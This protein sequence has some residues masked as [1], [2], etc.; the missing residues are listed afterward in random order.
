LG[1]VIPNPPWRVRDLL[2]GL[3]HRMLT[4][5]L[6]PGMDG[7]GIFFEDFAAALPPEFKPV[8]VAYPDDSSLGYVE[9]EALARAALPQSEPYLVL[10][11]SFSGPIAISI[12][13][14]NPP[15]LLGLILCVTFARNPHPLLP[16][17]CAILKPLPA[18]RLPRFIQQ[19][20]LFGRFNSPYLR[21]KLREI[22]GLVSP[23]T[24]KA[25]LEA[26]ASI[27]VTEKLRRVTAPTLYLRA[28]R[29]RVV[30]RASCD[31]IRKIHREVEVVEL[32]APHLL[33]QTVPQAAK[34]EIRKFVANR[35][36]SLN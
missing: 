19:P 18:W 25:R 3:D 30:S 20:N 29:D 36:E 2:F 1:F 15:G 9:L 22:R 12:A 28:K 16:L 6:L 33:L 34:T 7:T 32:D 17:V 21:A 26:V 27:D 23:K 13:A 11:E 14:S 10:G 8:V 5:V 31:Y 35:I 4:L 24:L